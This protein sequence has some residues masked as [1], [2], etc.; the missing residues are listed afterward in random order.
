MPAAPLL[1]EN[2]MFA[3]RQRLPNRRASTNFKVEVGGLHYVVT[4]SRFDSGQVGEVFISNHQINSAADVN[5]RDAAIVCSIALQ[6]GAGLEV[7]RK[8]IRR[9]TSPVT[10]RSKVRIQAAGAT[11]SATTG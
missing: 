5:A 4:Y 8:A 6:F 3:S 7:I 10:R 2:E 9:R 1:R 11:T